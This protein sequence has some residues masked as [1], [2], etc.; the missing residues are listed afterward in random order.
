[1]LVQLNI[2]LTTDESETQQQALDALSEMLLKS[3][4]KRSHTPTDPTKLPWGTPKADV[5]EP[6]KSKSDLLSHLD[7]NPFANNLKLASN[8]F[9][10]SSLTAAMASFNMPTD[11]DLLP[12]I[13]APITPEIQAL[14][15][16]LNNNVVEIYTWVHN[17]IRFIPS[18][19]SIQGAQMTMET[20]RGNAMDT[21]SLTIAL[22]RA[23]G[24]PA[25]YAYGTVEIDSEKVMNWVGGVNNTS[26]AGNLMGQGGIPNTGIV[27]GGEV[28]Y[29]QLEH[30]WV[31]AYVDFDASRGMLNGSKDSWVPLD[32]SFKQYEFT[33]GMD[34]ESQVPFDAQ[35]LA[36]EIEAS[37]TINEN[38]GWVQNASSEFMKAKAGEYQQAL[39]E[40]FKNQNPDATMGEVM[41]LQQVNILEP[42]PLASGLPYNHIITTQQFS[43][44]PSNL[45]HRFKYEL[46]T[47]AN[48]YINT[49]LLSIDEPTVKL[50]GKKL[51]L[52]FA[53]ATENDKAIIESY[54]PEPD[55]ETG[56]IN[57]ED[58]PDTLPGYLISLKAEFSIG[59][60]IIASVVAGRMG[61]E[62]HEQLGY[63]DPRFGWNLSI[64]KPI[65][66]EYQAIGLDLQGSSPEYVIRLQGDLLATKDELENGNEEAISALTTHDVFG[67][68][69]SSAIYAYFVINNAQDFYDSQKSNIVSYR[70]PSYGKFSTS[71]ST[72]YWFGTPR[73]VSA[74][75]LVMDIDRVF[76][77]KVDKDNNIQN[78][79]NYNKVVGV[80]YSTLEHRIPEQLFSSEGKPAS[81]ISSVKAISLASNQGQKIWTISQDNLDLAIQSINLSVDT[82]T[83]IRNSVNAGN[84]VT[85]HEQT[86]NFNG[87]IGDGYTIID[88]VTGAGAYKIRGGANGGATN[89]SKSKVNAGSGLTASFS[90][91]KT[92]ENSGYFSLM[93][94]FKCE[95]DD[96]AKIAMLALAA[97]VLVM[98]ARTPIAMMGIPILASL[99]TISV[100]A[101][102]TS[103]FAMMMGTTATA[104]GFI[105]DKCECEI[106]SNWEGFLQCWICPASQHPILSERVE[107]AKANTSGKS[108]NQA[109][110]VDELLA[111]TLAFSNLADARFDMNT[112]WYP[113]GPKHKEAE[114][115][116]RNAARK[117]LSYLR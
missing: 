55:L 2:L 65:V 107:T 38:E 9:N 59:E 82:E 81:G 41:G 42:R 105:D 25:R 100:R 52:S 64:N 66:G 44:V 11:A 111:R 39:S 10:P 3:Q 4:F 88:P 18:Y 98:V 40:Y 75:G 24:I 110:P 114:Q 43:E 53:P 112:C 94:T 102:I 76:N 109:T 34:L 97:F 67:D 7:I 17:N 36:D 89:V 101:I 99:G 69:L 84:V 87:W 72:S 96:I 5:R 74:S 54:L 19:G 14:A 86:L 23:S 85:T 8:G 47:D 73:N 12:T 32:A 77:H 91:V 13:D 83:E 63:W 45:R 57:P 50:A 80:R 90:I 71:L 27:M 33:Q 79:L 15:D 108:C 95:L 37:A 106:T 16:S 31:E 104:Q 58:L 92:S 28:K 26:A 78:R 48:E 93:S 70:A 35:A 51:V 30:T 103:V 21:A 62:L 60:E 22:L 115:N 29:F 117:C 49:V 61:E 56:E 68:F 6:A 116:A 46:G 1:M 113:E 20:K